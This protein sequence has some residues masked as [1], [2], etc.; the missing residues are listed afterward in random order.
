[1]IV[2]GVHVTAEQLVMTGAATGLTVRVSTEEADPE[3]FV[4]PIGT[5]VVPTVVGVPEMTPVVALK[6]SPG[7][8]DKAL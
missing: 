6:T 4:A 5:I 3:A 1:M 7:G 8:R 2:L